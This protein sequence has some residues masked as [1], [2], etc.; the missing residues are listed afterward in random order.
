[1]EIREYREYKEEEI[2]RLYTA[3]GWTAY[4]EDMPALE[5]GIRNSLLVLGAYEYGELAGLIR[6]VGDGATIVFIQDILVLPEKQRLVTFAAESSALGAYF[7]FC[8]SEDNR[9]GFMVLDI[10]AGT[11]NMLVT[12][13][14]KLVKSSSIKVGGDKFD[15]AIVRYFKRQHGIVIGQTAAEDL[16]CRF[17]SAY[18]RKDEILMDV[19]G[20]S[21]G[22]GLPLALQLGSNEITYALS[23]PLR[24]IVEELKDALEQTPAEL[25]GDITE[26]GI[27]LTGGSAQLYG[28]D[29]FISE[30]TGVPCYVAE[31]PASCVAIGA[32]RVLVDVKLYRNVLYDYRR[33]D[34][35]EA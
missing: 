17:G 31:D 10:G 24:S 4:T 22:G 25:C 16:K 9:G 26:S 35:Y 29:K 13:L 3:V 14:G 27:C 6:A 2:R 28:L 7:R 30:Q 18:P 19:K 5:R 33:G 21:L 34:Y 1:M 23:E 8:A 12:S 20:R 32:G 15:A 11:S